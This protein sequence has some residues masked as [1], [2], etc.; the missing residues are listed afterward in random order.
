MRKRSIEIVEEE[1]K[2]DVE[3]S[4]EDASSQFIRRAL[5]DEHAHEDAPSLSNSDRSKN[6]QG[7]PIED[8]LHPI[9]YLIEEAEDRWESMLRRQSQTL[10]QAVEEYTRRYGMA[11]P[12]GFDSW[13]RY[14][15]EN[16]VILVDEYD[17]IYQDI[18]PF[19][20]L[21]PKEFKRRS[22]QLQT[23]GDLPWFKHSFGLGIKTG[24]VKKF[25]G[26]GA[27]EAGNRIED[28]MDILGEFSEMM[29]EDVEMRFMSGDE[30]G[31]VVSGEAKVRHEHYAEEGRCELLLSDWS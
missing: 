5:D 8:R 31:V 26:V 17:Q 4:E 27:T 1:P 9:S 19:L 25:A 13:W 15:M 20:S 22:Q 24:V 16:R 18:L 12:V 28:L 23:D 7:R 6:G 10:E 11:P 14:A 2:E 21:G 30:P 3:E 29:P